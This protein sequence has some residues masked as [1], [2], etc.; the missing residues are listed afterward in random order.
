MAD[1]SSAVT[2]E[3]RPAAT[4]EAPENVA[5]AV[6]GN[7]AATGAA[8]FVG[9]FVGAFAGAGASGPGR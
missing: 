9:G 3:T 7:V 8:A 1:S 2:V 4:V 5:L 6:G